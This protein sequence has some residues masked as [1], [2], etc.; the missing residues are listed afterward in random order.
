MATQVSGIAR[1]AMTP[2]STSHGTPQNAQANR[3]RLEQG[4]VDVTS[5]IVVNP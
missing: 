5:Q 4:G 2:G 3:G 1:L